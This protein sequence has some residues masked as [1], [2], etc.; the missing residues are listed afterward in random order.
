[1]TQ[2]IFTK[3]FIEARIR[4]TKFPY[5]NL[6][7]WQ[8]FK[9][10][11]NVM[12]YKGGDFD[13]TDTEETQIEKSINQLN[14]TISTFPADSIFVIELKNAISA[15]QNG[16]VGPFQ[17]SISG[18]PT[19]AHET[20]QPST[21]GAIPS[22]YVPEAMLKGLQESM[23]RDIDAK[24][25]AMNAEFERKQREAELARREAELADREKEVKDMAKEYNS[26]VAK[27]ADVLIEIG[28]KIGSY[29][30][31][32]RSSAT[33]MQ[34]PTLDATPQLGA[35][36]SKDEKEEAVDDFAAFLYDNFTA[37][38]IRNLKQNII[39]FNRNAESF[40]M[41]Q[42]GNDNADAAAE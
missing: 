37:A 17:F 34:P 12:T 2:Q 33:A 24:I 16:I 38:D 32:P 30:L 10:V 36:K 22:G 13:D 31:M 41:A 23:Q 1:M 14:A 20:P 7:L 28:K 21:L 40:N 18:K 35:T 15:N 42:Q 6:S 9:N 25:E 8:G 19:T 3:D 39:N 5:W 11:A 29:F 4:D 26:S 27:A